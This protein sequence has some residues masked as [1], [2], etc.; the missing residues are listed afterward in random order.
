[1]SELGAPC[2][3]VVLFSTCRGRQS[4]LR[5]LSKRNLSRESGCAYETGSR[6]QLLRRGV[7]VLRFPD[8]GKWEYAGDGGEKGAACG[9]TEVIAATKMVLLILSCVHS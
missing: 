6:R 2:G 5:G 9:P 3:P 1:M 4:H 8:H 7:C